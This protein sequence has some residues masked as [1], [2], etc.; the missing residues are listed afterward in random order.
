MKKVFQ[1]TQLACIAVLFS[2]GNQ[3]VSEAKKNADSISVQ[4]SDSVK[5]PAKSNDESIEVTEFSTADIPAELKFKGKIKEA[6]NYKDKNGEHIVIT[7]ETG[8]YTSKNDENGFSNA[9]L[10]AYRYTINNGTYNQTMR[11]NDFVYDCP[12]DIQAKFVEN[13][14][15][16][17]DLNNNGI[18]EIWVMYVTYCRSDMSPGTMKIIMYEGDT[19][20]AIRGENKILVS[21]MNGRK[22]Y[23]GGKYTADKEIKNGPKEFLEFGIKL[24]E[25]HITGL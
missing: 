11:V 9:E 25:D 14:F 7:T 6:I 10:Y 19:K 20:Y 2:C 16:I 21:D 12:L 1:Y 18:A 17:T 4:S 23:L 22:E 13:T 24:W 5:Q 8:V 3:P 15:Q